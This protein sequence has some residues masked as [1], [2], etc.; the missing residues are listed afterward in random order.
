MAEFSA[1]LFDLETAVETCLQLD[2]VL[3]K[4]FKEYGLIIMEA[5]Q[6]APGGFLSVP[7]DGIRTSAYSLLLNRPGDISLDKAIKM[8]EDTYLNEDVTS[9]Y[10]VPREQSIEDYKEAISLDPTNPIAFNNRGEEEGWEGGIMRKVIN[11]EELQRKSLINK[12]FK[13]FKELDGLIEKWTKKGIEL[14]SK[15]DPELGT[16]INGEYI[17]PAC[18][19]CYGGFDYSDEIISEKTPILDNTPG[20]PEHIYT[21]FHEECFFEGLEFRNANEEEK[22]IKTIEPYSKEWDEMICAEYFGSYR[23]LYDTQN[24]LQEEEGWECITFQLIDRIKVG[25]RLRVYFVPTNSP[26]LFYKEHEVMSELYK[27]KPLIKFLDEDNFHRRHIDLKFVDLKGKDISKDF[28]DNEA[29]TIPLVVR[30]L[31]EGK[32]TVWIKYPE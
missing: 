4:E 18:V 1:T 22:E 8:Y 19:M 26:N 21:F 10:S 7:G 2:L 15:K 14:W 6:S 3:D 30:D 12:P 16:V 24:G 32:N 5:S 17:E 9:S 31:F 25:M 13:I 20:E 29:Q 27:R 23:H 11:I 28:T